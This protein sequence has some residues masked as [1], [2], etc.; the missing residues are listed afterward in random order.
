[1]ADAA[2]E[3]LRQREW[4]AVT[5][6]LEAEGIDATD[7]GRFGTWE[8]RTPRFDHKACVPVLI[9][10]LPRVTH[11]QVKGTLVRHLS[12]SA[13]RPGSPLPKSCRPRASSRS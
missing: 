13:A 3:A 1:M 9:A 10:W 6:A 11:P 7:F 2:S 12:T 5:A 8:G 4:E